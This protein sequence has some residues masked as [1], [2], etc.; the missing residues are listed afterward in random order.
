MPSYEM[1]IVYLSAFSASIKEVLR[2]REREIE[3]PY[4]TVYKVVHL[5]GYYFAKKRAALEN[6]GGLSRIV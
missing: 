3:I 6:T 1:S 4:G 2:F 5:T